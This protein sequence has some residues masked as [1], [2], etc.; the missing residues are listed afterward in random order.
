MADDLDTWTIQ[1]TNPRLR[2]DTGTT[3]LEPGD[4]GDA[5]TGAARRLCRRGDAIRLDG[6]QAET[7]DGTPCTRDAD[8]GEHCF[9]HA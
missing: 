1:I 3:V 8:D 6:C 5:P 9:Q 4:S 7:A 2:Y